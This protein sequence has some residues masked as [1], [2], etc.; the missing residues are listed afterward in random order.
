MPVTTK[1]SSNPA[2]GEVYSIQHYVIKF[3]SDRSVVFSRY[4]GF[5]HRHIVESV[6]STI[7]LCFLLDV[8]Y[9]FFYWILKFM[10]WFSTQ[11]RTI[12]SHEL[13]KMLWMSQIFF[14]AF[15]KIFILF[16]FFLVA[17]AENFLTCDFFLI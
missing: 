4:S 17:G 7:I 16:V 14:V 9:Y 8:A 13:K 12:G 6:V 3:V 10:D 11:S 15:V 5:L 1:V 2:N